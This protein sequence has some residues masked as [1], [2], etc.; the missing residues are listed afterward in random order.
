[1]PGAGSVVLLAF[2]L[3]T[4]G[5]TQSHNQTNQLPTANADLSVE[6]LAD[7]PDKQVLFLVDS[8]PVDEDYNSATE[9]EAEEK[10]PRETRLFYPAFEVLFYNFRGYE[11]DRLEYDYGDGLRAN[12]Y[13][14]QFGGG[15]DYK[16][17][18]LI[19][20][21]PE[22]E[23]YKEGLK[24]LK[25]TLHISEQLFDD[26]INNTLIRIM[27]KNKQ[28][29]F[30]LSFCYLSTLYEIIDNRGMSQE[31]LDKRYKS[32]IR[33]GEKTS[34]FSIKD[35]ANYYF[36]AM[37]YTPDMV[38]VTVREGK[39]VPVKQNTP[40]QLD[41]EQKQWNEDLNRIK[42]KYKL[43]DTLV[44]IPGEYDITAFLT[45]EN[46]LFSY[47]YDAFIF[48]IERFTNKKLIETKFI[49]IGIASGC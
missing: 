41:W 16:E 48:R 39:V 3:L 20:D 44:V 42:Q 49:V 8:L 17:A 28:D 22:N 27:P 35:S 21:E 14:C 10:E 1:M 31:E 24:V 40:A 46:K 2:F 45:R 18:V 32:A 43:R 12:T 29:R 6:E 25:D 15:S 11:A 30:R 5:C 7:S 13:T 23:D 34:F 38:E 19:Y 33:K 9:E 47:G 26:R 36:R 37:P 4:F